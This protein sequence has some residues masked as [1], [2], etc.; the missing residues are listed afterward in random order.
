MELRDILRTLRRHWFVFAVVTGVTVAGLMLWST[1]RPGTF[2]ARAEVMLRTLPMRFYSPGDFRLIRS[3]TEQQT[4]IRLI[5]SRPVLE[6]AVLKHLREDFPGASKTSSDGRIKLEEAMMGLRGQIKVDQESEVNIIGITCRDTDPNRAVRRVNAIA[7]AFA[8]YSKE[9]SNS[10]LM[11]MIDE[12]DRVIEEERTALSKAEH[13]FSRLPPDPNLEVEKAELAKLYK[14]EGD[15]NGRLEAYRSRRESAR[16]E[17]AEIGPLVGRPK[18]E[19]VVQPSDLPRTQKLLAA[20]TRIDE[21]LLD[22]RVR[23]LESDP[24]IEQMLEERA[25]LMGSLDATRQ[26]EVRDLRRARKNAMIRRLRELK[27]TEERAAARRTEVLTEL[28]EVGEN[29]EETKRKLREPGSAELREK[30]ARLK[31]TVSIHAGKI[32]VLNTERSK[33]EATRVF[34]TPGP[35]KKLEAAQSA[36]PAGVKSALESLFF[37][38]L[39]GLIAGVSVVL[40]L[41][42]TSATIRTEND[43]KRYVNLPIYGIIPRIRAERDRLLVDQAPGSLLAEGFNTIGTILETYAD[44]NK[45]KVFM[46]ASPLPKEGKSTIFS[47]IAVA[48][49]RGRRRVILIDCDL[50][51]SVLH[52]FFQVEPAPGLSDYLTDAT[53]DPTEEAPRVTF[54]QILKPTPVE[55]LLL[56]PAGSASANPVAL[57]KSEAMVEV[58]R[59]AREAC[60]IVLVDVPPVKIA[61]DTLALASKVDG[62]LMLVSSGETRK[63][64]VSVAKRLVESAN[65][66]LIGCLLNKV[67]N[68]VGGYYY[69]SYYYQ[70]AAKHYF[71]S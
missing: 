18:F 57:L 17:A 54:E 22:R 9:E 29:I 59:R 39:I 33:L 64:A 71:E 25:R 58:F 49:A 19:I 1:R 31:S 53:R 32:E 56:I 24:R 67:T 41:E 23:S 46:I 15:L 47:N 65:G 61:V 36:R 68:Q 55:N 45:A 5:T 11:T 16:A 48:M 30:R 70:H 2:V 43:V 34:I 3:V 37:F 51:R 66:R 6:K 35:V 62:M 12:I 40:L 69:Y 10:G 50:R 28:K 63:D 38:G 8:E 60:D 21:D 26:E 44:E 13:D 14:D 52:R 7:T 27:K 42:Y 20:V 4:R